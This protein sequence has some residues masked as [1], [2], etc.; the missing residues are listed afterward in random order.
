MIVFFLGN[1][2]LDLVYIQPGIKEG[3]LGHVGSAQHDLFL[4]IKFKKAT[5]YRQYL[6]NW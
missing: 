5:E 2:L 4:N 1:V 3:F 6:T